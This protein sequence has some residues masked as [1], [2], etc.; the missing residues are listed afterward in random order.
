M[1]GVIYK[2]CS[3]DGCESREIRSSMWLSAGK[4]SSRDVAT[5]TVDLEDL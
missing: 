2:K 1:V 4:V 5:L 3:D